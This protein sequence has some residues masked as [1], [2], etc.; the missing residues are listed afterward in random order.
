MQRTFKSEILNAEYP[1]TV[2]VPPASAAAKK[3][4]W[5]MIAFDGGFPLMENTLDNLLAA[6]KIPPIVVVGVGNI[7]E[8]TRNRDL[9]GSDAFARFLAEELVPWARKNY[10]VYAGPSHTIVEGI[11]LGGLMAVYCG[12]KRSG[13][14]GKVLAQSPTLVIVPGRIDP[15]P[16]WNPE[17]AGTMTRRFIE[18]PRLPVEFYLEAGRYEVYLPFSLLAETRRLRDTLEATGYRVT[19]SEFDGGHNGVC[20]RGSIADAL[21]A[22]T[23]NR[24][25]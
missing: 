2:Y 15:N 20:W 4:P 13:T 5:L 21:I 1:L 12:L 24:K 16:V 7:S 9:D 23:G 17:S 14:F 18:S 19:Y 11:S 3:K 25:S 22:L 6:G 10:P 8:E